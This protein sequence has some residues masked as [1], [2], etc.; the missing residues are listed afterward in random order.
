MSAWVGLPRRSAL[1]DSNGAL[2]VAE[3]LCQAVRGVTIRQAPGWG[4]SVS[5][6]VATWR[7]EEG[8]MK[9]PQ[10]LSRADQALYVAKSLGKDRA[11]SY[12]AALGLSLALH[13]PGATT[14]FHVLRVALGTIRDFTGD[15]GLKA[16]H[17]VSCDTGHKA[18]YARS[19][20]AR[21]HATSDRA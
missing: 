11:V 6:G 15:M 10:L 3:R 21:C 19:P 13:A 2:T 16:F 7:P 12:E 1:A 17:R 4:L 9:S 5:I 18:P 14:F 20:Y 8:A